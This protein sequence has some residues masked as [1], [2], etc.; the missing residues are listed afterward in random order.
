MYGMDIT[1]HVFE[2]SITR[3]LITRVLTICQ[4][5]LGQSTALGQ[6][7]FELRSLS[8]ALS[9]LCLLLVLT[10]D[11]LFKFDIIYHEPH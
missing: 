2:P 1:Q 8:P 9:K 4:A 7:R 5:K 6:K 10:S 11:R 3:N